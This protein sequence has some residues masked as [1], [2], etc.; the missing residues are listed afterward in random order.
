MYI[1]N[2]VVQE[3]GVVRPQCKPVHDIIRSKG[4]F[5]QEGAV[6]LRM[7]IHIV[8]DVVQERVGH[9]IQMYTL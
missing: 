3:K 4:F 7:D 9:G 2:D 5:M 6:V 8:S 1:V